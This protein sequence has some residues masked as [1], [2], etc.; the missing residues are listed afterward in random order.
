MDNK[1]N[2]TETLFYKRISSNNKWIQVKYEDIIG[3]KYNDPYPCANGLLIGIYNKT[4]I[5]HMV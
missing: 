3:I 1:L 5:Q 2:L 4:G